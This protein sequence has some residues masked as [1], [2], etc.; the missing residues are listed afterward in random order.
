V[1]EALTQN[2][3]IHAAGRTLARNGVPVGPVYISRRKGRRL[4][5]RV[6]AFD[7]F[8]RDLEKLIDVNGSAVRHLSSDSEGSK[9][10]THLGLPSN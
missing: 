3:D 4:L 1:T 9:R 2:L 8:L 10:A 7:V 5:P 6:I